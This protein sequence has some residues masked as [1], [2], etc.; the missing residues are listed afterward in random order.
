MRLPRLLL[1]GLA[2][3]PV[4]AGC[5][6]FNE[7][8][9]RQRDWNRPTGPMEKA[10]PEQLVRY[11]NTRADHLQTLTY[12]EARL[13]ARQ[14]QGLGLLSYT[15]RGNLAASQPRNFRMTAAGGMVGGK[16]D[17]G[18]NPE[19]FWV[20]AEV[21]SQAPVFVYA[22][23][24]DFQSG[25]AKLPGNV[26][27]EPDWVMQ[28]LGMTRLPEPGAPG[29]PA[30][31]VQP[32][33]K[34]GTYVLSW[35]AKT[36]AGVS[37]RRQVVF[38]AFNARDGRPQVRQY[39]VRDPKTNKVLYSADVKAVKAVQLGSAEVQYP[40]HIV[41]RSDDQK[42]ELD[43]TLDGAQVNQQLSDEQARRLFNRPNIAGSNPINLA[44]GPFDAK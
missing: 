23:H 25:Q 12:A 8:R 16:V 44:G 18:S 14:G 9:E 27:F 11:L 37:V 26:P 10:T 39:A 19:Q 38:D 1:V 3:A 2:L 33:E 5:Q 32:I 29:S 36:P 34:D 30:Y 6:Q 15:L 41:L 42:F 22:S 17:L 31:E 20:Y 21:P 35:L 4:A 43:L 40:T 28:G 24:T 7:W 13:T